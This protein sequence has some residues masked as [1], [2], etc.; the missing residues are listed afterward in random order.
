M[1]NSLRLLAIAFLLEDIQYGFV[2]VAN[3]LPDD[4][5]DAFETPKAED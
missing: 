2:E 5:A 3:E 4:L 1:N